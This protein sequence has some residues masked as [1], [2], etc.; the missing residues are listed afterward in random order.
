MPLVSV[1]MREFFTCM[2]FFPYHTENNNFHLYYN[3]LN[4]IFFFKKNRHMGPTLS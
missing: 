4:H 1:M 2:K 3:V